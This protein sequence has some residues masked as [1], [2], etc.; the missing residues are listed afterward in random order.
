VLLDGLDGIVGARRLVAAAHSV[1]KERPPHGLIDAHAA[2]PKARGDLIRGTPETV[3]DAEDDQGE[4]QDE[5][6]LRPL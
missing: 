1:F 4:K 5:I 2:D 3:P 6:R